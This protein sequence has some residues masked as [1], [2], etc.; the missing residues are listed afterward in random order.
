LMRGLKIQAHVLI[1]ELYIETAR[2][3][4]Y[5]VSLIFYYS[6]TKDWISR[7][8]LFLSRGGARISYCY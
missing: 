4:D 6:T 3:N 1:R 8:T 2:R 5:T 7:D